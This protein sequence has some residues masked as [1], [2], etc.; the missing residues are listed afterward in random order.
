MAILLI[1]YDVEVCDPASEVTK[2]FLQIAA[3]LH[4]ELEAPCSFFI[5][6]K[7]LENNV[8]E[9]QQVREKWGQLIDFEQ[10][11][12]SH[13][14]LKTVVCDDGESLSLIKGGTLEEI[15]TEVE[16]TSE[17]LQRYLGVDCIGLTGPWGY[18]RGLMDRPDI[19]EILYQLGIRF[20]RTYARNEKD[21]QPVSFEV[22]PFWYELQGF[23]EILECPIQWWQD[24]VWRGAHGWENKEEYLRQLRGNIDYIAQHDL[25][26]GYVQHD[27]SS[28]KEDP[29]MSIIRNLIEYAD[30]RG[31]R[32]MSYRQY[33]Q[34]ALRMRPQIPS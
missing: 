33:Y 5:C 1:G 24:C 7:T 6:G 30:Q 8:K 16:R 12:Y 34:E 10:H 2:A 19:L 28:L 27:W 15:R 25:V 31:I 17:L 14:L 18:Y 22:Q 21:Y 20:T 32:L 4:A 26:W 3:P 13:V 9:F 11:T 23:P 29:D